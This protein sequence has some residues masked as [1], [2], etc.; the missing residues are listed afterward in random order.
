MHSQPSQSFLDRALAIAASENLVDDA[1]AAIRKG[2][3]PNYIDAH[4]FTAAL[5][6]ADYGNVDGVAMVFA[7]TLEQTSTSAPAYGQ[8]T[9][10]SQTLQINRHGVSPAILLAR[11]GDVA[12]VL[13]LAALDPKVLGQPIINHL[14]PNTGIT[15]AD[16]TALLRSGFVVDDKFEA[17][18]RKLGFS[19][20]EMFRCLDEAA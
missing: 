9:P 7:L 12:G 13:R 17:T 5:Y 18:M 14:Q 16:V 8:L 1:A 19:T 15:A 6:F 4:G 2:A 11:R 3:N 10:A 20:L